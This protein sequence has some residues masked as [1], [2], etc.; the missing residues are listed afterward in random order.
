MAARAMKGGGGGTGID[1]GLDRDG[2]IVVATSGGAEVNYGEGETE[3]LVIG[4]EDG[5]A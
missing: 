5:E 4:S 1:G 2:V 3:V